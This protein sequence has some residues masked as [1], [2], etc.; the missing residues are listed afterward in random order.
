[1]NQWKVQHLLCS[2]VL[3]LWGALTAS[4]QVVPGTTLPETAQ[5][6]ISDQKMGSVL[7][8]NYYT[9]DTASFGTDT[10]ITMT[11]NHPSSGVL[12]HLY[13][14]SN[15][16]GVRNGSMYLTRSQT[17][18]FRTSD[19]DPDTTGYLLVM[20]QNGA[21]QPINFNFLTGDAF[22]T[23]G[24]FT[25]S[26]SAEAIGAIVGY[27]GQAIVTDGDF[28]GAGTAVFGAGGQYGPLPRQLSISN[29]PSA[30][31]AQTLLIV[32]GISSGSSLLDGM[33]G[34]GR[35]FALVYN[36][37]EV[38]ASTGF[39]V[40]CQTARVLS[41]AF[42]GTVPRMST[43]IPPGRSGWMRFYT[44]SSGAML[45]AV[46]YSYP[47]GRS[48]GHN[49]HKLTYSGPISILLPIFP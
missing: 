35:V 17:A 8:Y 46:I 23:T 40:P 42:P 24:N 6:P 20:A 34:V 2:A 26:L 15:S 49:L 3:L 41:D 19:F 27:T 13:F 25:A 43:L 21:G 37:V 38:P 29:F 45:G 44:G 9:S 36:D 4:A 30:F 1:M 22:V 39:N 32:N 10:R 5:T 16:C 33:S 11:N 14:V 47:N 28:D 18:V 31:D 12:V 7:I 48:S